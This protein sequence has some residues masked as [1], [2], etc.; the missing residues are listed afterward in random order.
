MAEVHNKYHFIAICPNT[1]TKILGNRPL[2]NIC[3]LLYILLN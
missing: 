2:R 1:N 3:Q